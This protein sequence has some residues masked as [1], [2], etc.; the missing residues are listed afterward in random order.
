MYI[1]AIDE[2]ST[3]FSGP[4]QVLS[5]F[6]ESLSSKHS[7]YAENSYGPYH[8]PHLFSSHDTSLL[9]KR[10]QPSKPEQVRELPLL[11]G[12]S[13][14][15]TSSD[16]LVD[17]FESALGDILINPVNWQDLAYGAAY[18]AR[19]SPSSQINFVSLGNANERFA[20]AVSSKGCK[21]SNDIG[22]Q[23]PPTPRIT[24]PSSGRPKIAVIGM[25]GRFPEAENLAEFWD[26]LLHGK[27]V[28]KEVPASRWN[29]ATHFDPT[30]K[31]KNTSGTPFGCWLQNPGHFDTKFFN[32]SPREAPQVDPASRIALMTAYEAMEQAGM[33]PGSTPSTMHDRVGVF[34]GVSSNDWME[35]NSSQN[36]DT[37]FIAGGCRA[38]IPGRVNY[39]F[40]FSG[41]SFSFD[42]ACSSSLS[43]T[44]TACNA[45]WQRDIDT[46][47]VGKGL[48]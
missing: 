41:P 5:S 22:N 17:L 8:A 14:R 18:A 28:H 44:H 48:H 39:F 21:L 46:A 11:F 30:G 25:S 40:K 13:G 24:D 2:E 3:I 6:K 29:V 36:I 15:L 32:M 47:I 37:Y 12:S 1:S 31:G 23:A 35:A 33:V 7:V 34:Y 42:T 45:L 20:A 27:D 16:R 26:I 10:L 9:L 4:P 43:A 38:F 19:F